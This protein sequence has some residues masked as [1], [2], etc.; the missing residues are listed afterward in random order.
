MIE[1]T[2]IPSFFFVNKET[3]ATIRADGFLHTGDIGHFDKADK[4]YV[5]DRKKELI[6]VKGFQ[7]KII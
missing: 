1:S 5:T 7:V 6:K 3:L 2:K 4:L